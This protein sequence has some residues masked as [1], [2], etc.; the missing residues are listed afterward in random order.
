MVPEWMMGLIRPCAKCGGASSWMAGGVEI[1][2]QE[3]RI[4]VQSI[5][6]MS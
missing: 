4:P 2:A 5:H 1:W 3:C 6:Q